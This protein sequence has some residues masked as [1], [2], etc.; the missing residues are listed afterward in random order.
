MEERK[1]AQLDFM[2]HEFAQAHSDP[3]AFFCDH[4]L[5]SWLISVASGNRSFFQIT[6]HTQRDEN[7]RLKRARSKIRSFQPPRLAD[8]SDRRRRVVLST[9]EKPAG[10]RVQALCVIT[11]PDHSV[12]PRVMTRTRERVRGAPASV[13]CS[14]AS[15]TFFARE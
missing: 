10:G 6:K 5:P 12:L 3:R 7:L 8:E 4:V 2:C 14:P 1:L 11:P 13:F 15:G 9:N